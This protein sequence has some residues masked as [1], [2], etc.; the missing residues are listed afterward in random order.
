MNLQVQVM[1]N[2]EENWRNSLNLKIERRLA[3]CR[4]IYRLSDREF[5]YQFRMQKST[6][7]KVSEELYPHL[8]EAERTCGLSVESKVCF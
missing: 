1:E 7:R 4:N 6:F 5:F 2:E 8:K 3:R